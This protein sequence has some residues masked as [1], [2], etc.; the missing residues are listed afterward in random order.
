ML[1]ICF[2]EITS[3]QTVD[4]LT[5]AIDEIIRYDENQA[6]SHHFPTTSNNETLYLDD[7]SAGA[8]V[9]VYKLRHDLMTTQI[10]QALRSLSIEDT[11]P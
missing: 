5:S 6:P 8:S 10:K 11:V 9:S 1:R 3:V 7:Y 2:R 4:E